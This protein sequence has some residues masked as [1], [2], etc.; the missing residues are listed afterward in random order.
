MSVQ[1]VRSQPERTSDLD[2]TDPITGRKYAQPPHDHILLSILVLL[3]CMMWP[4]IF[5]AVLSV[6]YSFQVSTYEY[7]YCQCIYVK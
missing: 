6:I 7:L 3:F 2:Y 1:I 4:T 5:C